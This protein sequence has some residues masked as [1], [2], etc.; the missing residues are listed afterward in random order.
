MYLKGKYK[1]AADNANGTTA[2]TTHEKVSDK[3]LYHK[4]RSDTQKWK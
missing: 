3:N 1:D 4:L 2:T